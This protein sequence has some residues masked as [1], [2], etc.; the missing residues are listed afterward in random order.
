MAA[1]STGIP[2]SAQITRIGSDMANRDISS[3]GRSPCSSSSAP[4]EPLVRRQG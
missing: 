2:S 1:C 3:I 4:A